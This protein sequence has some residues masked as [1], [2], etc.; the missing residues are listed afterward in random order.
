MSTS[1]GQSDRGAT[2]R[3]ATNRGAT[4]RGGTKRGATLRR[5]GW[6]ALGVV[7]VLAVALVVVAAVAPGAVR[8]VSVFVLPGALPPSAVPSAPASP[9]SSGPAA[10]QGL[11]ACVAADLAGMSLEAQV[12]QLLMVGTKVDSPAGLATTVSRY[13]LGGV[14]LQGRSS[15][16]A[17]TL[18]QGVAALQSAATANGGIPVQVGVDQEGGEVQTL[19]G[20]DFP[21]VPT[22]VEQGKLSPA[23]LGARTGDM[24]RRLLPAGITIDLAPVADT[25]PPA[26]LGSNPPIAGFDRQYGSDPATVAGDISTVVT[27]MQSTGLLTTV[28]HFPGLGRVHANTDTSTDAV[29][30]LTTVDDP[31]LEP[32]AAAIRAGTAAVMIS[33]AKYPKLDPNSVAALSEPIITGLLRQRLGFTGLVMSDDMGAAK[34]V[35]AVSPGDRA[36]RFIDAGGDMVLTVQSADAAPM[37]A[38]LLARAQSSSE[39]RAKVTASAGRVLASKFRAGLLKCAR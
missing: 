16:T 36:V 35:S 17:A 10:A 8:A 18:H 3:G 21:A 1:G 32:F 39:F 2:N 27:A 30:S 26:F 9:P 6:L 19:K 38:A 28:K 15:A 23:T 13:H 31:F 7:T 11:D 37:T 34:A 33:L 14:F 29:D 22:A 5:R 4:N 12:G 24:A 25:V 20:T